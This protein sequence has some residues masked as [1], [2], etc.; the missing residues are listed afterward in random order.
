MEYF[1]QLSVKKA[2]V[3]NHRFFIMIRKGG[4]TLK[5]IEYR[6]TYDTTKK[7]EF[8]P[9]QVCTYRHI[10]TMEMEII[11]YRNEGYL[12]EADIT[13]LDEQ[14]LPFVVSK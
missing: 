6:T 9:Y 13:G 3:I 7:N 10:K 14:F 4:N 1:K 12:V 8:F 2:I 5:L 11:E